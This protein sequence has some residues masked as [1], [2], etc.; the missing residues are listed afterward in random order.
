[1]KFYLSHLKDDKTESQIL[2]AMQETW[3]SD[4]GYSE[5]KDSSTFFPLIICG[6]VR[7]QWGQG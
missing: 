5:V 7:E 2:T 3:D 1:M 4:Q 6:Q